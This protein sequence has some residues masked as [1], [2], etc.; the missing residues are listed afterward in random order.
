M[1]EE[2]PI[3]RGAKLSKCLELYKS[4]KQEK[5]VVEADQFMIFDPNNMGNCKNM[6]ANNLAR[7]GGISAILPYEEQNMLIMALDSNELIV[8]D[9]IAAG[10]KV[11]RSPSGGNFITCM[12]KTTALDGSFWACS[13][14][15]SMTFFV[16]VRVGNG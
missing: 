2:I 8:V 10:E 14:D 9:C 1:L 3:P 13:Y 16:P 15:G 5:V 12:C 6:G 7:R 4:S 11:Y